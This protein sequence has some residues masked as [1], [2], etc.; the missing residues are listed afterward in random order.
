MRCV[1]DTC[2]TAPPRPTSSAIFFCSARP[3]QGGPQRR[4]ER[5]LLRTVSATQIVPGSD[6]PAGCLCQLTT[7]VTVD[8]LSNGRS[9]VTVTTKLWNGGAKAAE[10]LR[11]TT[12]VQ[13]N[14]GVWK[15]RAQES[16]DGG[17]LE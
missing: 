12:S 17:S 1:R 8:G 3:R 11:T 15:G 7:R 9:R 14:K 10:G 4:R 6:G 5:Q 2:S 16:A 13:T